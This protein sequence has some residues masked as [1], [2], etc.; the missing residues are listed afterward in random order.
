MHCGFKK[1]SFYFVQISIWVTATWPSCSYLSDNFWERSKF[2]SHSSAPWLQVNHAVYI[3]YFRFCHTPT[4]TPQPAVFAIFP[5][6]SFYVSLT[7]CIYNM[8]EQPLECKDLAEA[9]SE[10]TRAQAHTELCVI[11]TWMLRTLTCC[12][13]IYLT[14]IA[15][16]T[17]VIGW[18]DIKWRLV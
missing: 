12:V 1:I 14:G 2:G 15:K 10:Q 7:P 17:S 11:H 4:D 16:M 9:M 8:L 13:K 6:L 3:W 18:S 5:I